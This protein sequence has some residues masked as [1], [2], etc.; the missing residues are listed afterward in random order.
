MVRLGR[1][2]ASSLLR[3]AHGKWRIA[4][5]Y[6]RMEGLEQLLAYARDMGAV[7][8]PARAGLRPRTRAD[9]LSEGFGLADAREASDLL[10]RVGIPHA[11]TKGVANVPLYAERGVRPFT[12]LD[13]F[14]KLD[15]FARAG[16][17]LEEA[18]Y[19]PTSGNEMET[20][21]SPREPYPV[22]RSIDLHCRGSL[23]HQFGFDV[24]GAVDRAASGDFPRFCAEDEVLSL[25][26]H[27][28]RNKY[29]ASGRSACDIAVIAGTGG[30]DWDLIA[31]RSREWGMQAVT[32][33][34]LLSASRAFGAAVPAATL[35]EMAPSHIRRAYTLAWLDPRRAS[36]LRLKWRSRGRP[37]GGAAHFLVGPL[38]NDRLLEGLRFTVVHAMR[39]AMGQA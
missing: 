31:A 19:E 39:R 18:G 32:W 7:T 15:D 25:A 9:A 29:T 4:V 23:S 22:G 27:M 24:K 8:V 37:R 2:V 11:F 34:A 16:S 38:L 13:V 12:D 30:I 3:E 10:S 17:A 21:Y 28:A 5:R 6:A 14:V 26:A 36:P 35:A 1:H 33:T 20:A